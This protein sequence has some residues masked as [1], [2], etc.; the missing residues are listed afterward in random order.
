MPDSTLEILGRIDTQIKLRGVRIES[1]GISS[2]IRKS[3]PSSENFLLDATTILAKHP[4][5]GTEQLVSFI[6]WDTSVSIGIRKSGRPGLASTPK[7]LMKKIRDTCED[8][9]ARYM[10]PSH[11]IPLDWLPLSPNGKADAKVLVGI[12]HDLHIEDLSRLMSSMVERG[13]GARPATKTEEDIFAVLGRHIAMPLPLSCH[14]DINIF[15]CGL[16]SMGVIRFA[17]DLKDT[18]D[19]KVSA[20]DIMISPT[21]AGIASMLTSPPISSPRAEDSYIETFSSYWSNEVESTYPRSTIETILPPFCVQEG[22]LSRSAEH[23]TMYVQHVILD[24]KSGVSLAHLRLAWQATMSKHPILRLAIV[25]L[26]FCL[27][28]TEPLYFQNRLPF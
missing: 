6:A 10:R 27:K 24:C 7:G 21:L 17:T 8:E 28:R 2:I 26:K 14:P 23:D 25:L 20:S 5:I 13:P 9:L 18:F 15:E 4:S 3:V 16:D 12:F 11:I 22:V 1:E 19:Q